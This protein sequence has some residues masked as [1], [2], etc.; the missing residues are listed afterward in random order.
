MLYI[1]CIYAFLIVYDIKDKKDFTNIKKIDLVKGRYV[2]N[3][4]ELEVLQILFNTDDALIATDIVNK[5]E[6]LTQSTVTAVLRKLLKEEL[7]EVTGITHSGRV[8]SRTY[9][10]SEKAKEILL[11]YFVDSYNSFANVVSESDMCA[12]IFADVKEPEKRKTEVKKLLGLLKDY[13]KNI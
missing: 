1:Y 12:A 6:G 2:M 4:R 5:G 7:V 8:L 11:Q 13:E 10:P 3:Q 9:R